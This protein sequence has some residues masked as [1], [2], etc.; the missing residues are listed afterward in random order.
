MK[1]GF[2]T[3]MTYNSV[4]I[5]IYE[6]RFPTVSTGRLRKTETARTFMLTANMD[7]FLSMRG[8]EYCMQKSG[9]QH[10]LRMSTERVAGNFLFFRDY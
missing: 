10:R 8:Y 3:A 7:E 1:K 9:S 5:K 6:K 4:P 2:L